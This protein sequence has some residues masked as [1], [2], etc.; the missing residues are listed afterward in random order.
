MGYAARNNP[1]VG[2]NSMDR[3]GV[4]IV[5]VKDDGTGAS[6]EINWPCTNWTM[7][8]MGNVGIKTD[9]GNFVTIPSHNILWWEFIPK[10]EN[11]A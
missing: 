4:V 2:I 9:T 1:I 8:P 7:D 3:N 6:E 10:K 11:D 5:R